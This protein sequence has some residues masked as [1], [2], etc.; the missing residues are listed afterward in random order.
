MLREKVLERSPL[1][2]WHQME[3]G[4][5]PKSGNMDKGQVWGKGDHESDS[6]QD[7]SD[8]PLRMQKEIS[9]SN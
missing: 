1:G 2:I 4:S 9:G 8:V 7:E 5:R 3:G 6:R